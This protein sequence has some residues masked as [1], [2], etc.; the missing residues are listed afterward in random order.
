MAFPKSI[1]LLVD[2]SLGKA[3]GMITQRSE[4]ALL[5]FVIIVLQSVFSFSRV[6]FFTQVNERALANIRRDLYNKMICLPIPFF[7]EKRVGELNSRITNDVSA[8]QDTLSITLAE[9]FRQSATLIIGIALLFYRSAHLT[10]IM[11]MSFP[12]IIIL[13]IYFGRFIR[14][15][16]KKTQDALAEA[17]IVVNETFQ[18]VNIVKAYTNE[19]FESKRFDFGVT[20]SM[21]L[22]L[23]GGIYRG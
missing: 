10:L 11:L 15:N 1:G 8:L 6:W 20:K 23:K 9:F 22:G 19:L 21:N 16:S 18:G 7:E 2:A 5:L 13:A 12:V 3:S 17:N 14:N 4:V